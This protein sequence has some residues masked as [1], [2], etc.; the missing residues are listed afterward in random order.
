GLGSGSLT[1]IN[2]RLKAAFMAAPSPTAN[3]AP[4]GGDGVVQEALSSSGKRKAVTVPAEGASL[5]SKKQKQENDENEGD[6][7][8]RLIKA[9]CGFC[10]PDLNIGLIR[11]LCFFQGTTPSRIAPEHL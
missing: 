10:I 9:G 6:E 1:V 5:P 2:K 8:T 11:R 7:E 3:V 4:E